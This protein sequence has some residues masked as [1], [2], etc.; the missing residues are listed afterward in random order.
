MKR[1]SI[2]LTY[3][4]LLICGIVGCSPAPTEPPQP[5][6]ISIDWNM[7]AFLIQ[8]DGTVIDSFP[9][10]VKDNIRVQKDYTEH[11][12][13]AKLPDS[14][15]YNAISSN[16]KEKKLVTDQPGDFTLNPFVYDKKFNAPAASAMALNTEKEYFLGYWG[17]EF[18]LYLVA[19][20]NPDVNPTDIIDHFQEF[21][22]LYGT[23]IN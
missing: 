19:C 10:V 6:E 5:E 22:N 14:F 18:G 1:F 23:L 20:T 17:E 15:R 21:L 2:I 11:E 13:E 7:T 4:I 8:A 3:A 9:I 16:N 12:F